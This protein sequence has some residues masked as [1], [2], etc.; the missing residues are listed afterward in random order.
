MDQLR[1]EKSEL[2]GCLLAVFLQQ[3]RRG[4]GGG[5]DK[6]GTKLLLSKVLLIIEMKQVVSL[7]ATGKNSGASKFK[8]VSSPTIG[9]TGNLCEQV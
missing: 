8:Q 6:M 7:V 3:K 4:G 1:L 2:Q 5:G 9:E